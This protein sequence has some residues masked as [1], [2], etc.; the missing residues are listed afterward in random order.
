MKKLII[1][2]FTISFLLFIDLTDNV[3]AESLI[4]AYASIDNQ[5]FVNTGMVQD[6][7][8]IRN[9]QCSVGACNFNINVV[10]AYEDEQDVKD[11]PYLLIYMK[12]D[13]E[14]FALSRSSSCT[15]SC[16]SNSF[17]YAKLGRTTWEDSGSRSGY[18]YAILVPINKYYFYDNWATYNVA[19]S[20]K[21]TTN[22]NTW[23]SY[24]FVNMFITKDT[25]ILNNPYSTTEQ[26]KNDT[27][28]IINNQ[29]Q[30]QQ[31]TNEKLDD[32]NDTMQDDTA[33]TNND[34][35]SQLGNISV[36]PNTPVSNLVLLPINFLNRLIDLSDNQCVSYNLGNF[37][38]TDL[39]LPCLTLSNYFG[40]DLWQTIDYLVCFFMI[41]N[42]AMLCIMAWEDF[43]SLRDDYNSLYQPKHAKGEYQPKHG[44]D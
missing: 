31:Q 9:L 40:T 41:Y 20:I 37:Y 36:A 32:L 13:D 29:N 44:G 24:Q 33:P 5:Y 8:Y 3:F 10:I 25:T 30:N 23:H 12:T 19:D 39:T 11:Y 17:Q 35:T 2:I 34:F 1:F 26:N 43:T 27:Q 28:N 16:F 22:N 4:P 21:L 7:T 18:L 6:K 14:D 15:T 38:G 42:F